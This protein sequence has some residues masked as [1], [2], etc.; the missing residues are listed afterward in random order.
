MRVLIIEDEFF[1]SSHLKR[2][3]VGLG[4]KVPAVCHSVTKFNEV[5]LDDFDVALIDIHLA[6]DESGLDVATIMNQEGKPFIFLTA[7]KEPN[8]L[9][10]AVMNKPVAYL[11]K[12]FRQ[13]ELEA[14]L[15]LAEILSPSN[16]EVRTPAGKEEIQ[17]TSILYLKADDSYTQIVT[18]DKTY[19][20]RKVLKSY[21]EVLPDNFIRVHRSY[22]VNKDHIT[23]KSSKHLNL[24]EH[25]IPISRGVIL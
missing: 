23:A 19:T 1:V 11:S 5:D 14:A 3:L 16:I 18:S 20:Q 21:L 25:Q 6:E 7:N 12:P 4:Y 24:G 15:Q 13:D 8:I 17:T 2:M 10:K 22:I 9:K